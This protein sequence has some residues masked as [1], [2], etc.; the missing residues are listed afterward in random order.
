[1][2]RAVSP[3]GRTVVLETLQARLGSPRFDYLARD[4]TRGA[5]DRKA[6][7][8]TFERRIRKWCC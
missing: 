6:I 2:V 4:F 8:L 7:A 3:D 5:R 1:V